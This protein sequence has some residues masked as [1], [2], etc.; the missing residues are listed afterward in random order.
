MR[1]TDP[2]E[3]SAAFLIRSPRSMDELPETEEDMESDI[4]SGDAPSG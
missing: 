1:E 3:M 2:A 4:I